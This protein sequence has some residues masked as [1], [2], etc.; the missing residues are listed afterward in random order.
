MLNSDRPISSQ[1][2]DLLGRGPLVEQLLNWV[3]QAPVQDGF[4]IGVTG[5]WGSGK[6]SVLAL[7]GEQLPDDVVVLPF[8]PWLFAGADQL[9]ELFF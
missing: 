7:L 2:E 9:V 3:L 6:T 1:A 5:P 8:D 4:V